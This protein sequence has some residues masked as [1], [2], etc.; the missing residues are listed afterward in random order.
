MKIVGIVQARM[1]STR[2]PGKVLLE[3]AGRPLILHMLERVGKCRLFDELWLA[4]SRDPSDEP[5]YEAVSRAGY[6]AHR[7]SLENVLS[8]FWEIGKTTQA[9]IVV[10]LT[11]DCP[12][13]DPSVI[14][15]V[16]RFYLQNPSSYDYVSNVLPPTYP[17]GLDT[18]L[19][20]FS[21]LDEAHRK[22]E[23]PYEIEH[24]TPFIRKFAEERD[25]TANVRGPADFSHLRWTVDEPEDYR[26][27]KEVLEDLGA[28]KRD[29]G[30][31]DILAWMTRD[32]RRLD[33]N[34]KYKRNEGTRD[35]NARYTQGEI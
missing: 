5:L 14:G 7:G 20:S 9:D 13:H 10:R 30:W 3:A 2:L 28:E 27:V 11:G 33:I 1:S 17:D 32:I 18:E 22:A 29:F 8:R 6:S 35:E 34:S 26:F 12:L 31:L 16:V 15:D 4:T 21:S 25:R 24:V 23:R 19:F